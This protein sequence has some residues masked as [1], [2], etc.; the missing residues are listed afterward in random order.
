[1]SRKL[2]ASMQLITLSLAASALLFGQPLPP[3]PETAPAKLMMLGTFHFEDA[4]LDGYKPQ[5][6]VD[7]LSTKRQRE[8]VALLD[9]LARFRPNKIAVEVGAERQTALDEQFA[10][11]LAAG[12]TSAGS[13]EIYQLGFR[14]ARRL[15]HGRVHAVD[16]RE[17]PEFKMVFTT[18]ELIKRAKSLGQNDLIERGTKWA[19]WYESLDRW[20]DELKTKQSLLDHLRMINSPEHIRHSLSRYLVAEFEVGGAGGTYYTGADWRTGWYNRNLRIF[21]NLLRLRTANSDRILLIIGAGHVPLLLQLA[22][23]APEFESV[24]VLTVLAQPK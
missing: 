14:L 15:G 17:R 13:N 2:E 23:N 4:G 3:Q 20:E 1:M 18:E 11:Y 24:P 9:A 10:R 12:E 21:S 22:Q 8:V 5:H 16:A 6:R 19:Q 7:L